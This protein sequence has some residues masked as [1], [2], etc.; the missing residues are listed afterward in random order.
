[1]PTTII[2]NEPI[3]EAFNR[4][5]I[6]EALIEKRILVKSLARKAGFFEFNVDGWYKEFQTFY[7]LVREEVLNGNKE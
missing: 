3:Q 4:R 6:E 2:D 7:D 5:F 1:M